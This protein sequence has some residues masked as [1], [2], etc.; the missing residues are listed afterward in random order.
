MAP[1][2]PGLFLKEEQRFAAEKAAYKKMAAAS[3]DYFVKGAQRLD[4]DHAAEKAVLKKMAAASAALFLKEEQR[5][6]ALEIMAAA[7]PGLFLK[8]EQRMAAL[9]IMAAAPPL[10]QKLHWTLLQRCSCLDASCSKS[11][12][13]AHTAPYRDG[14][15]LSPR[16]LLPEELERK[17]SRVE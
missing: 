1:A 11:L 13:T 9:E 4:A 3:A 2:S 17:R 15:S 6:A 16:K 12:R 14:R 5:M 7:S 10:P 8:E